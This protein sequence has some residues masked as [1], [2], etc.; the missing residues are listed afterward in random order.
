MC[1]AKFDIPEKFD[2][3]FTVEVKGKS[4]VLLYFGSVHNLISSHSNQ[5][6]KLAQTF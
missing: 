2:I 3:Y 1:H 4:M 6:K 5:M